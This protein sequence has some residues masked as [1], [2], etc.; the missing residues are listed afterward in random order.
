MRKLQFCL[1]NLLAVMFMAFVISCEDEL[2]NSVTEEL[3]TDTY[4]E[5]KRSYNDDEVS[6]EYAEN[7]KIFSEYQMDKLE[8]LKNDSVICFSKNIQPEMLPKVNDIYV[9]NGINDKFPNAFAGKV[10]SVRESN[11][12]FEVVARCV[13]IDSIFTKLK[14][15][16]TIDVADYKVYDENGKEIET[17]ISESSL[18]SDSIF[19][20]SESDSVLNNPQ[21]YKSRS[22]LSYIEEKKWDCIFLNTSNIKAKGT[23]YLGG[24]VQV[25]ADFFHQDEIYFKAY[26]KG[27]IKG[28]VE[29]EV[30]KDVGFD[31][32]KKFL[33]EIPVRCPQNPLV[34]IP[35]RFYTY[36]TS[37]AN[38]KLS[39]EFDV[40]VSPSIELAIKDSKFTGKY[41]LGTKNKLFN[42]NSKF[43]V[44]GKLGYGM[45]IR[46]FLGFGLAQW[47]IGQMESAYVD[48]R[49][50][51]EA[52]TSFD[53]ANNTDGLQNNYIDQVLRNVELSISGKVGAY[54]E[55]KGFLKFFGRKANQETNEYIG[56]K[57]REIRIAT[58][59]L[60]PK[61]SAWSSKVGTDYADVSYVLSGN[62]LIPVSYGMSLYKGNSYIS[63]EY[64]DKKYWLEP[65]GVK[66]NITFTSLKNGTYDVYPVFKILGVGPEIV[67][68]ESY[69]FTIKEEEEPEDT[70]EDEITP[71]QE[72]DL[73]L[74]V[75]WASWNVG[76][77]SP[78]EYGGYYA[79]GE[80]G[81]KSD[82][83]WDTYK[84]WVDRN[85][86]GYVDYNEI[87][88]I[89]TNISGT[90]YD[91]ARQKWGGSW[92]MPTKAEIDE[93]TSMCTWTWYQYKG[94]WGQKVTGP[95]GNS[96]FMPAAGYRY[97]TSLYDDG[98]HGNY[99]SA[100]LY[101][102]YYGNHA[103]S[104]GFGNGGFNSGGCDRDYGHTVRPVK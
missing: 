65:L 15:N 38:V 82:Y 87:T 9:Y 1:V 96:I 14:I 8:G 13:P 50:E 73:G 2:N 69:S 55:K 86:D 36:T 70:P 52:N 90:Q 48:G 61:V 74:S 35:L 43:A 46:A 59:Y 19:I 11:G 33:C 72:V 62:L 92:R 44:S 16:Q 101:E 12:K 27:G 22:T 78:E 31:D 97:G 18:D 66:K 53:I 85:G 5:S 60:L 84:Y 81:E 32:T 67:G 41:S 100:T 57:T 83:D 45:G 51:I 103:W 10:V 98:S 20:S 37:D 39:A 71:G 89:G 56:K 42:T 93:L 4:Q 54:A 104:L 7:V 3:D 80:T 49:V 77:S 25:N 76:A 34:K 64:D 24:Y 40:S 63:Q 23:V 95:N 47:T 28:T 30:S 91:V 88:N 99:W 58:L 68:A 21:Q 29:A 75:N 17:T 6:F 79:W 102:D 94:V 26:I